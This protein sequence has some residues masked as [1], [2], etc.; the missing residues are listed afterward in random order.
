MIARATGEVTEI[1][2]WLTSASSSPTIVYVMRSSDS[3]S[4][5]TT[6]APN[7]TR[8]PDC[9]RGSITWARAIRSSSWRRRASIWP[10]RSLAAWYS[11]FS[12][13]SPWARAISISRT[14]RG[15]SSARRRRSSSSSSA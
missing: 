1:M 13:M 11:A 5:S 3:T 2:P 7:V 8:S 9:S 10:C 4:T 6:V 12:E 14:M 15:R